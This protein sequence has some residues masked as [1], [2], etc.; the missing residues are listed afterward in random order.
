MDHKKNIIASFPV[1]LTADMWLYVGILSYCCNKKDQGC[2]LPSK[3]RRG[4]CIGWC[5]GWHIGLCSYFHTSARLLKY[6]SIEQ[7]LSRCCITQKDEE[8]AFQLFRK[9]GRQFRY[10]KGKVTLLSIP[11]ERRGCWNTPK[12]KR[13]K[14]Q[15]WSNT[16]HI[17]MMW[18]LFNLL[19]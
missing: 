4:W 18:V 10:L 7:R 11:E 13:K 8:G 12:S 17:K 15:D 9:W 5:I 6:S 16:Q 1:S 3:K 2:S 19:M 14:N